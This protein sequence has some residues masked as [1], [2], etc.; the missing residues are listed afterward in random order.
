MWRLPMY[1]AKPVYVR[2]IGYSSCSGER[3]KAGKMV[4]RTQWVKEETLG[5]P[6]FS[7]NKHRAIACA[8]CWSARSQSWR[9]QP[10]ACSTMLRFRPAV[11]ENLHEQCAS[12][13]TVVLHYY[14][15]AIQWRCDIRSVSSV[16]D[17]GGS[18]TSSDDGLWSVLLSVGPWRGNWVTRRFLAVLFCVVYL[19]FHMVL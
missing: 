11:R 9:S 1:G 2:C 5:W 18:G 7:P 14:T 16:A 12:L 13:S 17:G 19:W 4:W 8:L 15:Y 6:W 3:G 10:M